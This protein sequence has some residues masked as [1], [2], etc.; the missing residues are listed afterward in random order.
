M[1]DKKPLDK[2]PIHDL[3]T[4]KD[5]FLTTS[6]KIQEYCLRHTKGLIVTVAVF[7]LAVVG[8]ALYL[9]YEKKAEQAAGLAYENSL[10]ALESSEAEGLAALE[11]VRADFA[12]RKASRLAAFR[13]MSLYA[14]QG[15]TDKALP[16]AE[17]LLS[18]I[19][20]AEAPLK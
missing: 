12:G 9:N 6:E 19:Q 1:S 10:A 8:V 20:A 4:E 13:L 2:K 16:L 3:L 7:A 17:E 14:D 11:K 18:T 15:E 5:A